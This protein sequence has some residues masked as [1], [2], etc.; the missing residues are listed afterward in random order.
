MSENDIFDNFMTSLV[1]YSVANYIFGITQ[2]NK[3]NLNIQKDAQIFEPVSNKVRDN[4]VVKNLEK[5]EKKIKFIISDNDSLLRRIKKN[6]LN[7]IMK[8]SKSQLLI[9][10][11]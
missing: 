1:G 3:K 8:K 7:N 4:S 9:I 11:N 10:I 2:R 6:F 5:N